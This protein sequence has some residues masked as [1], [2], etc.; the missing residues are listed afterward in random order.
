MSCDDV[1]LSVN[2]ISKCF[3]MYEKP[4]HRLFQTLCAGKKRFYKEFWALKD[5]SFNVKRGECVG[6]V[7]RNGAGKSTLLQIITGTLQA[8]GGKVWTKGRI[9]ALL[10]LGSGFNPEFTGRENVYMNAAI[11]G[12]SQEEIKAKYQAIVDFADIGEFIDQPVKTYSSGMMVRLAFSVQIMIEPDLLIID[13]ALAVGDMFF[14]Q[15]CYHYL[16]KLR[17]RGTTL[18]FVSH[19][20]TTVRSLC[21]KAVFLQQ[22]KMVMFG[23]SETVCDSYWNNS[24]EGKKKAGGAVAPAASGKK[25]FATDSSLA[26]KIS[27]RTGTLALEIVAVKTYDQSGKETSCFQYRD[28]VEV[29]VSIQANQDVPAGTV[30]AFSCQSKTVPAIFLIASSAYD[31]YLPEMKAGD[32]YIVR[33][34]FQLPLYKG[35]YFLSFSLKPDQTRDFYYDHIFNA[36]VLQVILPPSLRDS[37]CWGITHPEDVA[38]FPQKVN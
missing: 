29:C 2:N 20:L 6:I 9:A 27:S 35:D 22:G 16:K 8:T 4:I 28:K 1:V 23:D 17:E 7:G 33:T 31:V 12:L 36:A 19:S 18:L 24:V 11:L 15:K 32:R 5:V 21:Q 26:K 13:E 30:F 34:C 10:E 3:E 25:T 14:Q 38:I 37:G